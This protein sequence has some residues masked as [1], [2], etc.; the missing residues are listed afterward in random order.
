MY[1]IFLQLRVLP[2]SL[3][4]HAA[5]QSDQSDHGMKPSPEISHQHNILSRHSP[6]IT[7]LANDIVDE[8]ETNRKSPVIT[9]APKPFPFYIIHNSAAD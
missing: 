3:T 5:E 4:S 7:K 2:L 1:D 8:R 9:R 6:V